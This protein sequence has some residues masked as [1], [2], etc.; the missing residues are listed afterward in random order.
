M[1]SGVPIREA[2]NERGARLLQNTDSS[3]WICRM[4]QG[5]RQTEHSILE[6]SIF[7]HN[8]PEN[9]YPVVMSTIHPT[10]YHPQ[11]NGAKIA[12]RFKFACAC[13]LNLYGRFLKL[14]PLY[15]SIYFAP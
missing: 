10:K 8:Q 4:V 5:G 13:T 3:A 6:H 1:H 11:R 7:M 2:I 14:S 15:S 12:R 9:P